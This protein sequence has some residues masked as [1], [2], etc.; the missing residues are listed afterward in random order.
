MIITQMTHPFFHLGF[1]ENNPVLPPKWM[2]IE[3]ADDWLLAKDDEG[4][5]WFAGNDTLC[6]VK[7]HPDGSRYADTRHTFKL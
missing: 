5:L 3:S 4:H 7:Y 6:R 2:Y 1:K